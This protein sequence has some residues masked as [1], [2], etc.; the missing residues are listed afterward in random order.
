MPDANEALPQPTVIAP[1]ARF[2]WVFPMLRVTLVIVA[3]VLGA[4]WL[5]VKAVLGK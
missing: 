4:V 3:G 2:G 5:G 1:P